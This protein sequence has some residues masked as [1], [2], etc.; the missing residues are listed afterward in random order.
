MK[1]Q[2]RRVVAA[3][4]F[5]AL[6]G[7]GL[8]FGTPVAFA[9]TSP[10]FTTV[11]LTTPIDEGQTAVVSGTFS[12]PDPNAA[13]MIGVDWGNGMAQEWLSPGLGDNTFEF[14]MLFKDEGKGTYTVTLTVDDGTGVNPPV[15]K[16]LTL[17]VR[18]VAPS[19]T[20]TTS[21]T[22][23]LDHDTLNVSGS[24]TDPG[25]LDTFT[26]STD[27]GDGSASTQAYTATA[28]KTFAFSHVYPT[29]GQY[30]VTTTV[31]DND[32]GK[33]T[34]TSP[35]TVNP[36]NTPPSNVVLSG[37]SVVAGALATI[38]GSFAD[39]DLTDTHTVSFT[40]GDGATSSFSLTA[41]V[42]SFSATHTYANAGSYPV[43]ATVSDG[44]A[45]ASGAL[46]Y[47]VLT[48][49]SAPKDLVLST[50]GVVLGSPTTLS[51]TFTDADGTDTHTVSV[52]WGDT[53]TSTLSLDAGVGSFTATHTYAA[54][55]SYTVTVKVAD[56][57]NASVSGTSTA[58][59]RSKSTSELLDDLTST[60]KSWGLDAGTENSLLTKVKPSCSNLSALANEVSA[61][62]NKKLTMD[63]VSSFNGV[64][65][66]VSGQLSC[67][68]TMTVAPKTRASTA[69]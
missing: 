33:G 50:P 16:T 20:M 46:S 1:V 19:V 15:D 10:S 34:S 51:G 43:A 13:P 25:V 24:F 31:T 49:N 38:R 35:L 22:T 23:L 29:P 44:L 30:K 55:G 3:A 47:V 28:P 63:Q 12:A 4:L 41:G 60:I 67:S 48:P 32:G 6:G 37:D 64:M 59:V 36:R 52:D 2:V 42:L 5:V 26:A 62:T 7:L 8:P 53:S 21:A 17:V 56:P 68:A 65:T 61:Q 45:S 11:A 39:P 54:T 14:K 27:W 58:D 57:A 18:N 9:D 66:Q 40:W 69:K